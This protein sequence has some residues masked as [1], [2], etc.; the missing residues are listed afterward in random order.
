MSFDVIPLALDG[1]PGSETSSALAI[2][3]NIE[4]SLKHIQA[5]IGYLHSHDGAPV[6]LCQ[7]VSQV[8]GQIPEACQKI[9]VGIHE[10]E[11]EQEK[12]K[13][14]EAI[15]EAY[16]SS[17][18]WFDA[19]MNA[20]RLSEMGE[21]EEAYRR[22]LQITSSNAR[23]FEPEVHKCA[24]QSMKILKEHGYAPNKMAVA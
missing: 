17:F 7:Q 9:V 24:V 1:E 19:Y 4:P 6:D 11:Q 21:H 18:S 20:K 23:E 13:R 10:H 12:Q 14:V 22:F 15:R 16:S 3:Q 8:I 5:A 2:I